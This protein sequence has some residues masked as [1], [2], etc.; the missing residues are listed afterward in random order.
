MK[1]HL[2][3][4]VLILTLSFWS[5]RSLLVSGYF[6]MHD[7]TQ[8]AR[9]V[10]M[11]R[12]LRAGQFPVRWLRDLGYGYGYPLFNFYG[13]LPYY[14]GGFLYALGANALLATKMMFWLGIILAPLTMYLLVGSFAG[15]LAGIL[16]AL[17]YLYAPYQA[18]QI[19]VR[20]AV[21]EYFAIGY[22]PLLVYGLLKK[23]IV[24][25]GL[26]LA[27]IIL[28]HTL[29]GY[30]IVLSLGFI[31]LIRPSIVLK[32]LGLGLAI[33]AF[34]WLPAF[35][36]MGYTSVSGQIGSTA[37]FR[38][39]FVCLSHLWNSG[40]GFGGSTDGCLDGM[41]FKLGKIHLFSALI[42][43]VLWVINRGQ[44]T[45]LVGLL[46]SALLISL[47]SIYLV[48]PWSQ[49]IWKIL[50]YFAYFQYPWR[51][52]GISAFGLSVLA[53]ALLYFVQKSWHR[54]LI[55]IVLTTGLL[56]LNA[57]LFLP[58]Y[59]YDR[60]VSAYESEEDLKFRVSRI[61][62]EYLQA[63]FIRPQQPTQIAGNLLSLADSGK[64]SLDLDLITYLRA[65]INSDHEQVIKINRVYFPGWKYYLN[66]KEA[67]PL[68]KNSLPA[69][70]L[71]SG[72][73][74][75]EMRFTNTPIRSIGNLISCFTVLGLV[76]YYGRK[77]IA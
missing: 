44:K 35:G 50:P 52:L 68:I 32:T 46:I 22:L 24:I 66:G 9:V 37:N 64:F 49:F 69:L 19:F 57:K 51:F 47:I 54:A 11:G 29:F 7:D 39:H 3:S 38:D 71:I 61:S 70:A 2:L 18:V 73:N 56:W 65:T 48:L 36:E 21:G 55:F 10:E 33:S 59:S 16:S 5:W 42:T 62:D 20:G 31:L 67:K 8:I 41:S 45:K 75:L 77:K 13:P 23:R 26:G 60:P 72:E 17:F 4:L 1:K 6:P 28:S 58:Q 15:R 43:L 25:A 34:F 30:L 14:F 40:W 27:G 12:A 53:G 63:D 76:L 74:V